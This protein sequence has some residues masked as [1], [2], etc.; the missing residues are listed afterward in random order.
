[1]K[2]KLTLL[3]LLLLMVQINGF[4]KPWQGHWTS[5]FGKMKF[6]E[7]DVGMQ[8][9]SIV[10]GNY[11]ED[12]TIAGVSINGILRGVFYDNKNQKG[13]S[14]VFSQ[15]QK[16]AYTG[17]WNFDNK[18]KKFSW[19][20]SNIDNKRPEEMKEIDRF[21]IAE[22][23]WQSNFG[24]LDFVQD[25]PF[26]EAKYSDKGQIYAVYNQNNQI[27]Y[28]FFINEEE[29]RYGLL[30]FQLNDEKNSFDGLWSWE[31]KNWSSQK[32]TGTKLQ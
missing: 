11:G 27:I 28:G 14:L 13:G 20:G 3:V 23:Q 9:A 18:Q 15:S 19:N 32:W 12:G 16:T 26:I 2:Q 5:T 29:G 1:M 24:L 8:Q 17:K 25:G 6:I 7:K 30:K 22:G 4:A 10:F 31:T 21:R